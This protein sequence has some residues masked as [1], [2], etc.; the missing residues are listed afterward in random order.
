MLLLSVLE[1]MLYF[2]K[3]NIYFLVIVSI[4]IREEMASCLEFASEYLRQDL[5]TLMDT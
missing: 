1:M 3:K 2:G 5:E 4:D